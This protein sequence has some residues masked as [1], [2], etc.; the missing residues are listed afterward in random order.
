MAL[1]PQGDEKGRMD[2]VLY[3]TKNEPVSLAI[4]FSLVER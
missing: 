4:A 3:D 1:D 2:T